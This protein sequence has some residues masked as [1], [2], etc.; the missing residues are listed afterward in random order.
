MPISEHRDKLINYEVYLSGERKLGMADITLPKLNYKT[1]TMSGAG[2]G[3]EISMPTIG[4]MESFEIGIKWRTLNSDISVLLTPESHDLDI[5]GANQNYDAGTGKIITERVK[6]NVRC[7]PKS[8]D[9]GKFAPAENSDSE[10]T[11]EVTYI[12]V[13]VNDKMIIEIDKLNYIHYINGKD[14]MEEVRKALGL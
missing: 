12:K 7:V 9:L 5:R 8:G 4:Q 10:N 11:M 3:G 1:G 2:I 13:S 6:V 14:Y